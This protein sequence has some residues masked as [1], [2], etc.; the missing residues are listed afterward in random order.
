MLGNLILCSDWYKGFKTWTYIIY[1]EQKKRTS[2]KE[3]EG[4]KSSFH[5]SLIFHNFQ[6]IKFNEMK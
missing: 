3:K 6:R 2:N 1:N 4:K 5:F